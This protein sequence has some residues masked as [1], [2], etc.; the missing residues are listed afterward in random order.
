MLAAHSTRCYP[1]KL[2]IRLYTARS[3]LDVCSM[4]HMRL[5]TC[6]CYVLGLGGGTCLLYGPHM[7]K[8][9][10]RRRNPGTVHTVLHE[11]GNIKVTGSRWSALDA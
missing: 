10:A 8:S 2:L 3:M 5:E 6:Y 9:I 7:P 1:S 11:C 4:D